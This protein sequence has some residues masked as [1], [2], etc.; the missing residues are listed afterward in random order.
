MRTYRYFPASEARSALL[1]QRYCR[2]TKKKY[3]LANIR[4]KRRKTET[5][6]A[7]SPALHLRFESRRQRLKLKLKLTRWTQIRSLSPQLSVTEGSNPQLSSP[8]CA[9]EEAAAPNKGKLPSAAN[10]Q[11]INRRAVF[12]TAQL[13][14]Q[15]SLA[16]S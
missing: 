8:M 7:R 9:G 1:A 11:V 15:T 16:R 10:S 2:K 5:R 14:A 6:P 13:I 4:E 3:I 12:L